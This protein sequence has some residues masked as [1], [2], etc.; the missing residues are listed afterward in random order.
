MLSSSV[1]IVIPVDGKIDLT[2]KIVSQCINV[3]SKRELLFEII[4]VNYSKSKSICNASLLQRYSS[5]V[6]FIDIIGGYSEA[7]LAGFKQARYPEIFH[8]DYDHKLN[9]NEFFTLLKYKSG[10]S[11]SSGITI[12]S[13]EK[14][15]LFINKI[16]SF[17][18]RILFKKKMI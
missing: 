18:I 15:H 13:G 6:K 7:L 11:I 9:P 16:L 14:L 1:S 12:N 5:Q 8:I 2:E 17:L 3:F 10:N 4:V